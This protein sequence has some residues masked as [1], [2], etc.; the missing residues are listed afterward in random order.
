MKKKL[1]RE[2]LFEL[3]VFVGLIIYGYMKNSLE[4]FG[5]GGLF[6]LIYTIYFIIRLVRV[7]KSFSDVEYKEIE[8]ELENSLYSNHGIYLTEH[9]I[10]L[11]DVLEVIYYKDIVCVE[12][13][14]SLVYN[15][16]L[17]NPSSKYKVYLNNGKCFTFKI[18]IRD[19]HDADE[20][21]KK[22]ISTKNDKV[23]FGKYNK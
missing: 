17:F 15:H 12:I 9:Y 19:K 23:Y 8:K 6:L 4:A 2:Y 3:V 22:I 13:G 14:Y 20:E 1:I 10:F 7:N 5:I 16:H 11:E 21:I 18:R